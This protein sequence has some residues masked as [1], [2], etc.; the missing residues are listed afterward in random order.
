[1]AKDAVKSFTDADIEIVEV[2]HNREVDA[3]SGTLEIA[4]TGDGK[5]VTT[6]Y[7]EGPAET[8]A[9]YIKTKPVILSAVA[10]GYEVEGSSHQTTTQQQ[11]VC[12]DSSTRYARSE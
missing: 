6:Q 11:C 4:L 8:T 7:L 10:T 9:K 3:P 1:M 12:V 5:S 2:H